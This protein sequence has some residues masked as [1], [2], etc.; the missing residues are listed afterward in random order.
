MMKLAS[1]TMKQHSGA[2]TPWCPDEPSIGDILADP[3]VRAV[4]DAD[5]VKPE[6]LAAILGNIHRK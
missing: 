6:H 1:P 3:I 4:M 2:A 5:G